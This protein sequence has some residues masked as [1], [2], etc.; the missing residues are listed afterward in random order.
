MSNMPATAIQRQ[1]YDAYYCDT[2]LT[3][4]PYLG[5]T[6]HHWNNWEIGWLRAEREW[7]RDHQRHTV[8]QYTWGALISR[9]ER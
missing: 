2:Q 1:G 3:S 8:A 5:K 9:R 4:N 6:P 7:I